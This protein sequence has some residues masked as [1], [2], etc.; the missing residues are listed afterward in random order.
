[1]SDI[2]KRDKLLKLYIDETQ[3]YI[4]AKADINLLDDYSEKYLCDMLQTNSTNALNK[5]SL[6]L[7]LLIDTQERIKKGK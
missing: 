3:R 5:M 7:D 4:N 2:S 6:Y 1:M